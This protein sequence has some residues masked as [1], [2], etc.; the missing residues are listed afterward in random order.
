[1]ED[2]DLN[3]TDNAILEMLR[4]GRCTPSYIADA[5]DYTR[6]NVKNRMDRLVEHGYVERIHRGLYELTDDPEGGSE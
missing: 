4:E 3:P 6:G 1:M 2:I 5:H